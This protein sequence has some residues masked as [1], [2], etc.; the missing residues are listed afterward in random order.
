MLVKTEDLAGPSLD[1]AV[2]FAN[3]LQATSGQT[4]QARQLMD[5]AVAA[6]G[7]PSA[8]T[9]W[10]I[11]GPILDCMPGLEMKAWLESRPSSRCEVHLHNYDGDWIAFGPTLLTAAMRCF[12]ASQL[13]DAVE[14]PQELL[15]LSA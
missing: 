6:N 2:C 13:G 5:R 15:E 10:S 4:E 12:V 8:S 11:G 1:W 7:L 3:W 9:D 14:I